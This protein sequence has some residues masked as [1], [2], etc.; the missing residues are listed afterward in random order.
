MKINPLL[1]N[2]RLCTGE[3]RTRAGEQRGAFL[4]PNGP[5]GRQLTVIADDGT[6]RNEPR[7]L[8][9]WEH[10]SVSLSKHKPNL[11]NWIEM[12]FVKRLF[13]DDEECVVQFHPPR[14]QWVNNVPVLHLWRWR[15]GEFPM[16]PSLLVGAKE[17]GEFKSMADKDRAQRIIDQQ[18][19]EL[20]KGG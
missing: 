18:I 6:D 12:D 16:P 3:Y 20:R 4:I 7:Q 14:S 9:G 2:Y 8:L 10:V 1:E 13:W 11:P 5:T 15:G 19:A 17:V